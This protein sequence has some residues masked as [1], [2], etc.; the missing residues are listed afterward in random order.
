MFP[1]GALMTSLSKRLTIWKDRVL[2]AWR[3]RKAY[4]RK[5]D[6]P[7][8]LCYIRNAE[9]L[10]RQHGTIPRPCLALAWLT[11]PLPCLPTIRCPSQ[12]SSRA[13]LHC[14]QCL[15]HKALQ[16][17]LDSRTICAPG[18]AEA[19]TDGDSLP[20]QNVAVCEYMSCDHNSW[21]ALVP[22]VTLFYEEASK[23]QGCRGQ[24]DCTVQVGLVS[25]P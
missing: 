24:P 8:F 12:G 13:L 19:Y 1:N 10:R 14:Y 16:L 2:H 11:S 21:T 18:G 25:F 17:C 9:A 4:L 22:L 3:E 20:A 23:L 7:Q 5:G 15:A 6:V